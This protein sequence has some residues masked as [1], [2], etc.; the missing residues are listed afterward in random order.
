MGILVRHVDEFGGVDGGYCI[1][2]SNSEG[3]ML[4]EFCVE[5]ELYASIA[6]FKRKVT[7]RILRK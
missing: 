3:R 6:W 7:V 2:Q 5:K 1:G 4:L